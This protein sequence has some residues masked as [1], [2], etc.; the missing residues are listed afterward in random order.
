MKLFFLRE[1][2]QGQTRAYARQDDFILAILVVYHD[3]VRHQ[4]K[5]SRNNWIKRRQCIS[6]VTKMVRTYILKF[7]SSVSLLF[8]FSKIWKLISV[9]TK[10]LTQMP[11][12]GIKIPCH[13]FVMISSLFQIFFSYS[14]FYIFHS[15]HPSHQPKLSWWYIPITRPSAKIF[16]N[17]IFMLS[18]PKPNFILIW[19]PHLDPR[20]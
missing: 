17:G 3:M 15:C 13:R 18:S 4:H 19:W 1:C 9:F 5:M 6:S 16:Y 10:Y 11:L 20:D 2:S 8:S 14:K 12:C 7:D